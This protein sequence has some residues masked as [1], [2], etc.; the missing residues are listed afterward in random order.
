MGRSGDVAQIQPAAV[1][2]DGKLYVFYGCLESGKP[3]A[4]CG[5]E[6]PSQLLER[7]GKP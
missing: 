5:A 1:V 7:W 6:T 3:F 4:V 2:A